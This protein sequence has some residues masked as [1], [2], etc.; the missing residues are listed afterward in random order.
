MKTAVHGMPRIGHDR[1]LKWALEGYWAGTVSDA[2]L[3]EVAFSIRRRNWMSMAAAKVDFIPSNDF[4]LYDHV[5]DAAVMVGAIAPRFASAGGTIDRSRYFAMARGGEVDGKAVAP[6]DLTKWF[7]TNYHH[8]VPE[9]GSDAAFA[10]DATKV[11]N[12]LAEATTLGILTTPVLLGPMTLVLRSASAHGGVDVLELLDPL[13][14]A[15]CEVLSQLEGGAA[16]VRFDEPAL[17]EERSAEELDALRRVYRRLGDHA[18]RPKIALSTYFGHLGPTMGAV[19]DLPVE[20][21]GLDFCRGRENLDLL[22]S[23]G[24]LGDKVLFAGLVDG[25][26][27]WSNELHTSLDLL[28]ELTELATEIVVSTSCSLLHVPLGRATDEN[29]DHEVRPWLAFA[30]DK[31]DE[32]AVLARGASEGRGVISDELDANRVRSAERRNSA[33]VTNHVIRQRVA[34]FADLDPRRTEGF[35][36]RAIDQRAHL[37]LPLLPTTTIGS[38]PQT[39]ELRRARASW[40]AGNLD[41]AGYDAVLRA[42]IDHVLNVQEEIGLDVLVHGEPERNDMVRYFAEQLS[43]FAVADEGWVQSYGSRCVRP[44]I[45]F[46]DVARRSPM[47]LTWTQYAQSRTSKPVKG[48]LTGPITMLR[49]SF[50]RDDQPERD[51]A[52]QLALAIRDELVDL[53]AAGISIIQVDEPALR[54]GLPLR[55]NERPQ[56]LAWATRAFRLITSAAAGATQVHTHMCYVEL[57]DIVQALDELDV[58]VLSFEAARSDMASVEVLHDAS[59]QGGVGPGV[60]DVHSPWVPEVAAIEELLRRAVEGLGPDRLWANPDCGLKTRRYAQVLPA[61]DHLVTAARRLRAEL[62]NGATPSGADIDG[63]SSETPSGP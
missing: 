35:A 14:D 50:V 1:A 21:V 55:S 38:F 47:T 10:P 53:Q 49:W 40:R 33:R 62:G 57:G 56:Y 3:D 22:R 18:T 13:V 12:E 30:D 60:Y 15:Y 11:R 2:Q 51:T 24:G 45:L 36:E 59:Y 19:R 26:N 63:V 39:S 58:D 43:G 27:I 31:L 28:D 54:E 48:M 7:D 34:T 23:G 52:D 42:E 25:R 5:L 44:P 6:L 32:L 17:V 29:I 4:S 46:G 41:D 20:A 37:A 9:F 16:W 61:L 8:L